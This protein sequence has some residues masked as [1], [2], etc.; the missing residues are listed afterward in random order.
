MD[1][2]SF[3][4]QEELSASQFAARDANPG[5]FT[6]QMDESD[7]DHVL[8]NCCLLYGWRINKKTNTIERAQT[9]AFKLRNNIPLPPP[10]AAKETDV[11]PPT[12][13]A[14]EASS[15]QSENEDNTPPGS[16]S[17]SLV[18]TSAQSG[19]ELKPSALTAE[20]VAAPIPPKLGAIPS[21]AINDR[22]RIEVTNV[23]SEFQESMAKN[24]FSSS[25][26]EANVSGG[27]G[28]VSGGVTGGVASESS[29]GQSS[30]NKSFGKKMIANYMFPR[31]SVFLR[32]EDLEPTAE[33]RESIDLVRKTKN[34]NA[35][36]NLY[37]TFGHLFCHQVTL[38]GCLQTTKTVSG[39]ENTSTSQQKESFKASVGVAV[40]S[41]WVTASVKASHET[42]DS[43]QNHQ[44]NTQTSEAMTFEATGGNT[45]LAADP[46]AWSGSVAD[47]N[48]WRVIEQSELTPIID[49]L[50]GIRGYSMV[51]TWFYRAV[52]TLSQYLV[53]PAS[54]I[55]HAR[56]RVTSE[57]ASFQRL[58]GRE[59]EAYLGHDPSAPP[60]HIRTSLERKVPEMQIH[61]NIS[62]G[63][64][65][66]V[67][68]L[69]VNT[70][71]VEVTNTDAMFFPYSVQAPTLM[72]PGGDD[73]GT[74]KDPKLKQTVWRL[75]IAQGYSLGVDSLVCLKSLSQDGAN[76]QLNVYRNQQGV[77]LPSMTSTD[78]P[79]FWRFERA[80]STSK[81]EKLKHGE[82]LRLTWRFSDQ[83]G[84]FRNYCDDTYGRRTFGR[85]A[86][87]A[88][89]TLYM[90][91]PYPRFENAKS[92]TGIS[93]VM[94]AAATK[95]PIV[96][97]IKVRPTGSAESG[98]QE[99]NYNLHDLTFRLDHVGNNGIGDAA[100]YMNVNAEGH[101][102]SYQTKILNSAS[103]HTE[104]P[105]QTLMNSAGP[106]AI[107]A[108]A[109]LGP[110][111]A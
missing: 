20:D 101:S 69:T 92:E 10:I 89:D 103:Q 54:R 30:S 58:S 4:V 105:M 26:V 99:I 77:F 29:S 11:E 72:F 47:F 14:I 44:S 90:K 16:E 98:T 85:P 81:D 25:S 102:E 38:G 48:N 96:E 68:D 21:Y 23:T 79:C 95:D 5:K 82:V 59:A 24:H 106:E 45:I 42:Q 100:D 19:A 104:P 43:S 109:L 1:T 7:W 17:G 28:P 32:P 78:E 66:P 31:V 84:G 53:I 75:E 39:T 52:P 71:Q 111:A 62:Y 74:L 91:V 86:G 94:S 70:I 55:L 36:R 18:S 22:S 46:P 37:S 56:F 34:I 60:K 57:D 93:I 73:V 3:K 51:K 65:G 61:Q 2:S 12:G 9:P 40:S 49:A 97:K 88:T 107:I 27:Y 108:G 64:W 110:V 33:L 35:L 83:A 8:R 67:T 6:S 41:P 50:A 80:Y 87:I 13:Q 63:P 15:S 76:M